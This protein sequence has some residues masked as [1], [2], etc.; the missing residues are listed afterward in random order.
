MLES[1]RLILRPWRPSDAEALYRCARSER[2]GPRA[3]WPVHTSVEMSAE[4]IRTVFSEP[5]TWA[6]VRKGSAEPIGASVWCR[7]PRTTTRASL[8]ASARSG[9]G[10]ARSIG[11]EAMP[12]RLSDGS[13][14]GAG[15][16]SP[17]GGSG[18]RSAKRTGTPAGWRRSAA[19][20][21][22]IR[23]RIR[24]AAAC[25]YSVATSGKPA[26]RAGCRLN[27]LS[28]MIPPWR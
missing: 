26:P 25:P 15:R 24:T 20:P 7:P 12:P 22:S 10:W 14:S 11:D 6:V 23:F 17:S 13:S 9:I 3:G 16:S 2:V 1:E 27:S 4:V 5:E 18:S 28:L 21:F 8:P 19:F